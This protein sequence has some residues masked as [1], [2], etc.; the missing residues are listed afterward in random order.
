MEC[1]FLGYK[2]IFYLLCFSGCWNR[3][4][5]LG[6]SHGFSSPLKKSKISLY[7]S[8][9]IFIMEKNASSN[10]Q[11]YDLESLMILMILNEYFNAIHHPVFH[12]IK[13]AV[14]IHSQITVWRGTYFKCLLRMTAVMCKKR[15]IQGQ[16]IIH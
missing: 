4:V 7:F 14:F 3:A 15:R 16:L 11:V 2:I 10:S 6:V 9:F 12:I 8:N 1:C 13:M 5:L